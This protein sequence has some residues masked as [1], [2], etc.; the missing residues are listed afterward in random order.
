MTVSV[1]PESDT[2]SLSARRRQ[3]SRDLMRA[4]ILTAA[5]HIIRS[6]GLDALSLRALAKSVGVSAPALY[7]YFDSKDAILRALFVQGSEVM[8]DRI[9]ERIAASPPGLKTLY[10]LLVGYCTFAREE[11][12]YFRLMFGPVGL[13]D[14]FSEADYA[15]MQAIFERFTGVIVDCIEAGELQQLP[16]QTLSCSLW[17][18]IHGSA[19][20]ETESF[21]SR[22]AAGKDPVPL[23][24]DAIRLALLAFATPNGAKVLDPVTDTCQVK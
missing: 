14:S 3:A 13:I 1:D 4:E 16:V 18:L 11:P 15:G 24:D 2:P 21:M 20:L 23:F 12:D 6:E 9:N 19:L 5:Q 7:E 10:S 8:L 17:A 22:K